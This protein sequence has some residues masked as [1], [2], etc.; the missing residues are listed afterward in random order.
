M[1][2][3]L[4]HEEATNIKMAIHRNGFDNFHVQ[5]VDGTK[6]FF[7]QETMTGEQ[8]VKIGKSYGFEVCNPNL[9]GNKPHVEFQWIGY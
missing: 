6:C 2:T 3:Y 1:Y 5:L 8:V 7:N 9:V 4:E